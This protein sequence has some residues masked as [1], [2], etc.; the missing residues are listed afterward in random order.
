M[1]HLWVIQ[2]LLLGASFVFAEGVVSSVSGENGKA[3]HE[4]GIGNIAIFND[5]MGLARD[6]DGNL[7]VCDARNHVIRKISS[8]GEVTTVAGKPGEE[9]ALDG[10]GHEARF[11]F[12][13]DIAVSPEGVLFVAD[14]GN[15]CIRMIQADGTV[16]TLAGDLGNADDIDRDYG[17]DAFTLVV[18]ELDG[19]GS[20]ARFDSP[21]GI[22]YSSENVLYVSDTG[23]HTI[24]KVD[25]D[26]V[27]S[28]VAGKAGE[29]GSA[30]GTSQVARFDSP[31]GLCLGE[32]GDLYIADSGNH[33]IRRI[34]LHGVVTTFSGNASEF[35]FQIGSRLDA[36][37][38]VPS[39]ITPHPDG[40]FVICEAF[41]NVIFRVDGNGIVTVLSGDGSEAT[42]QQKM[43]SRPSAA[44]CD[45]FGNVYVADTFNQEI[46]LVIEKFDMSVSLIDGTN[47]F[48]ITW[49]SL[50]GRNYRLQILGDEGW[51]N[52][53]PEIYTATSESSTISF[54]IPATQPKG[55]YR[56]LLLGY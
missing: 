19:A 47:Q 17:S 13:A 41:G 32:S 12:P 30:D 48:A 20:T 51:G 52:S 34:D 53:F 43:L 4:D 26:G 56:I 1:K 23:N 14:S 39:D 7:F 9:G 28:T 55:I 46:V 54:P 11:R 15:H 31:V 25:L 29:W 38:R 27:V 36:R 6:S 35:G 33:C 5:P 16:T 3:G 45:D 24:R 10:I 21:G 40:G 42:S 18:Q 49:D 8:S 44:V 2:A 22:V 50:P 37:Y